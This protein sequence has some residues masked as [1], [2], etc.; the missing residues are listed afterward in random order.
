MQQHV[1]ATVLIDQLPSHQELH[2]TM[3]TVEQDAT[4]HNHVAD[5]QLDK[6]GIQILANVNVQLN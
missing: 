3:S 1:N 4:H 6:F 5:A 2:G